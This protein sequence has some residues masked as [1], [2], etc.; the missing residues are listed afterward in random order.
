M[1]ALA[2]V[3]TM[4]FAFPIP[5]TSG[6]FNFG[7]AI[8]MTT[9]LTF[10][11]VIGALAG[12]IGSGLADLI[13]GW[14]NW[15]IFTTVIKGAEGYIAGK[16]AGDPKNRTLTKTIIAWLVGASVMVSGY[17]IVQVFMYGFSAALVEAPF[18]LVQMIV[19]GVVGVPLSIA[20]KDRLILTNPDLVAKKRRGE[21]L[22]EDTEIY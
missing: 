2:T 3:A 4:I 22:E 5:A 18:N 15:V 13:G 16:L 9:A 17:F 21:E 20:I 19:A 7:D 14:Y 1:G 6:Y 8:V 12:G 10:G 11:P